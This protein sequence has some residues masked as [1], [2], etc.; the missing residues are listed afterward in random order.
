MAGTATITLTR[1]N[2]VTGAVSLNYATADG[3]AVAGTDYIASTGTVTFAADQAS[4]SFTVPILN[5]GAAGPNKTLNVTLTT[6]TG[7]ATLGSPISAVLTIINDNGA[8]R[9]KI[10]PLGYNRPE[11]LTNFPALVVL[12]TNLSGFSY[13][14]FGSPNGYDLRFSSGNG[15]Q[16]LNYEVEKWNTSGSSYIWVQVP[17][18]QSGGYIWATWGNS[19]SSITSAPAAYTTNGATWPTASYAA[20]WHMDQPNVLDSTANKLNGGSVVGTITN[21]TGLVAGADGVANGYDQVP[22]STTLDSISSAITVSGWVCFNT[23]PT[24]EQPLMR[25]DNHWSLEATVDGGTLE[26]RSALATSGPSGW[27]ASNDDPFS[28]ALTLGKWYYLA[29][30]Y[31]GAAGKLWNFEN[32]LPIGTSPHNIG[33]T[34]SA[35][36]NFLGLGGIYGASLLG[37]VLDELRVEQVFRSTNWMW[38]SY[39]TVASNTSFSAY[40][41]VVSGGG[42]GTN[43]TINAVA[44][45]NGAIAPSGYAVVAL[46]S[47][48]TFTMTPNTYCSITNVVVD[49]SSVGATNSY[50][51]NNVLTNHTIS[52]YFSPS[53]VTNYTITASAGAN[54]AIAPSGVVTL[55]SGSNQTFTITGNSGYAVINVTVDGNSVGV[56]NS[57]TFNNVQTNHTISVNFGSTTTNFMINASAGA[58]GSI[59]P[60]GSIVVP[61]GSSQTF[62]MSVN[63]GYNVAS[64]LVDGGSVGATNS[65]TFN[66]VQ[67]NHTISVTFSGSGTTGFTAWTNKMPITFSGYNKVETL[68]NFPVL[69]VLNTGLPGF[70]YSQFASTNGYDLR[71]SADGS[72]QLN[73]E[74]EQW[75]PGGSSYVW[76]QVPQLSGGS[77]IW[78]YWGNAG[79]ASG[80]AGYTINGAVWPTNAF[81]AVWHMNQP[82]VLDSTANG[83]N[84]TGNGSVSTSPGI[85]GN[86]QN[87]AG[88]SGRISIPNSSSLSFTATQTTYSGWVNFN[89]LPIGGT[90]VVIMRKA[91]NRELGFSDPTHVRD[92]LSTTGTSGWTANNDDPISLV[93]GQWYYLTFTYNGSVIRSFWNGSPLSAGHTVTGS[94]NGDP[95]T[96][97]LGAYNGNT[98]GGPI[99]LGLDAIIDEVRVEQ[100]FRSPNWIWATYLTVASNASFSVYGSVQT[101]GGSTNTPT[102]GVPPSVWIQHYFPGTQTNNYSSLAGSDINSNGLTVWQ[103]YVAGVNPTNSGAT[104]SVIITNLAGQIIVVVPSVQTNSDYTG[105]A[106]YY[107]IDECTNLLSGGSWQPAPGYTGLQASGGIIACTNGAQNNATFYRA[108][109][110][111]Q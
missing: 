89:T 78:A 53:S 92:M 35:N 103:D 104:F 99:T 6:P 3:T 87:M 100:V 55:R 11:T 73:Y 97:G 60:S 102:P 52:A 13:S 98:D 16:E 109:V 26:L 75:N 47:S 94:I 24:G 44:G 88:G 18:L 4:Q 86:A 63:T 45:P 57:Y 41:S 40:G 56:T 12:S 46:G 28:P 25:K 33:A 111:L 34:I 84:G 108:K 77:Q 90:E 105:V 21:A 8:Y 107:E 49:G 30:S 22:D 85:T 2:G 1:T 17:Q 39:L 29:F 82:D 101:V 62:T 83:N 31:S 54:G 19:A 7:G 5:S 66:N 23:L 81:A 68:T 110:L 71:F 70:S 51:F 61:G 95:Y 65:Y 64:V 9:M 67:T 58:N 10:G 48:Q 27:T 106:R 15:S 72:T 32:G 96:T 59:A 38:A 20:V 50:S 42:G 76:V 43:Y 80:P 69:V 14:Q 74:I 91:Q 36:N 79:A 37:A 93:A